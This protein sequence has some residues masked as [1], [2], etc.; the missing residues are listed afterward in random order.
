MFECFAGK[1]GAVRVEITLEM[2]GA[3]QIVEFSVFR[4]QRDGAFNSNKGFD[5]ILSSSCAN[6]KAS[7][8]SMRLC[9]LI[10]FI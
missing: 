5:A 6:Q 4:L 7:E 1:D 8:L 3:S 2:N 9:E 10:I